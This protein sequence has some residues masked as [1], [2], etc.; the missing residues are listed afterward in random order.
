[1]NCI[2]PYIEGAGD[3]KIF[4]VEDSPAVLE[5]LTDMVRDIDGIELVGN[6]G[7]F[8]DA[9]TGIMS[10]RP[11][12]A[13]LDIRLADDHGTGID[14]LNRVRPQLPGLKA[15]VL[16]NYATPQHVKASVDA[17]AEYFL[18]KSADFERISEIIRQLQ[19]EDDDDPASHS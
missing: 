7:N 12:V 9:V 6:A 15:I 3:M 1:M 8:R 5:R 11:E 13:I 16:S 2:H 4:I 10:A 18:D 14:V 17:G 19:N